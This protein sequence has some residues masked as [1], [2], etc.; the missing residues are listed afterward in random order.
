MVSESG[1]NDKRHG[2]IDLLANETLG[3]WRLHRCEGST[4]KQSIHHSH[5]CIDDIFRIID[6]CSQHSLY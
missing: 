6:D 4:K 5:F 2:H 3:F 1:L